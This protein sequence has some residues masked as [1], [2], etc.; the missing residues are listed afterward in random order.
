FSKIFD[1]D[2]FKGTLQA[3][4]RIV[5]SLPSTHLVPKQSVERKIPHDISLGWISA[6]F[7]KQLNEGV[8]ILKGLD[9]KL[10][11][12]LPSDLQ[13]LRC[14]VAFHALRVADPVHDIGNK[15]AR[16]MWIEGPFISLHL[17]L[18]KDVWIRTGCHTGLGPVFDRIIADEQ[19]FSRI[20][21]WKI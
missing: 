2:H 16:K 18:E 9:S 20:S 11:K 10:W 6:R 13:K 17:R 3:D 7:F 12:N 4:V 19:V 5:S 1:A 15:L 14:K 21:H 8:L